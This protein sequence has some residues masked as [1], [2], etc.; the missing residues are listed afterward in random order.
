MAVK[1]GEIAV[2]SGLLIGCVVFSIFT[3]RIPTVATGTSAGPAFVPWLML[4]CLAVFAII[5]IGK[6]ILDAPEPEPN[7]QAVVAECQDKLG[8]E[9]AK[10]TYLRIFFFIGLL[11]AYASLFMT[12][13]Y[14]AT[15]LA[16]FIAGMFLLGERKLL[17][18]IVFPGLIVAAIYYGFTEHLNVW[19]P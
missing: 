11:V 12:L 6:S 1:R 15:T 14:F 7:D 2:A 3:L 4:A 13:G 16:V 5:I 17:S 10:G 18:L 19:L 8:D 9:T